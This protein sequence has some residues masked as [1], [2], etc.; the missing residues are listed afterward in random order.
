MSTVTTKKSREKNS[1]KETTRLLLLNNL[2]L[3]NLFSLINFCAISFNKSG[4]ELIFKL[5][6]H[7][8]QY[9]IITSLPPF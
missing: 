4:F 7:T 5:Y 9:T 6:F 1:V 3:Q 8:F 2:L